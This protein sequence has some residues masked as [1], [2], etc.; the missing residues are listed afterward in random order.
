MTPRWLTA[1]AW[2][3]ALACFASTAAAMQRVVKSKAHNYPDAPVE[4]R[5]SSVELIETF[6]SPT[7]FA[8]PES[9][10]KTSRVRY[11][12]R[13]GLAP[14]VYVLDGEVSCQNT[15]SQAVEAI[16]IV[17]IPMDAFHQPVLTGQA[18]ASAMQQIVETIPRGASRRI[19]WQQRVPST[20]VYEVAVVITRV[21]FADG[22]IWTAPSEEL[23]DV[24]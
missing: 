15:S 1:C 13:A 6:T 17:V 16:S 4:I 14:S 19:P 22:T 12:N 5:R 9:K 18:D 21:R 7:Q 20:D 23:L 11:A 10:A 3:L 2:F 8:L 24:F